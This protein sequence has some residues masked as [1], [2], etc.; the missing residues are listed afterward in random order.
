MKPLI[1]RECVSEYNCNPRNTATS[2][3]IKIASG[4]FH[5]PNTNNAT[6]NNPNNQPITEID[7]GKPDTLKKFAVAL[8]ATTV[9]VV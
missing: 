4:N 2:P 9:T 3:E 5:A 6:D 8:E 1:T 7:P